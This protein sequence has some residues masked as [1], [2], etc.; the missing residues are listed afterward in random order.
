MILSPSNG[1]DRLQPKYLMHVDN[2]AVFCNKDV[3]PFVN[4]VGISEVERSI[5]F[6]NSW[7]NYFS[8]NSDVCVSNQ[9]GV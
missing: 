7:S 4:I 9:L 5:Q 6:K 3:L 2:S 1:L 8:V